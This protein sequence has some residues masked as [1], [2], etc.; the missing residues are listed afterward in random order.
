MLQRFSSLLK[1]GALLFVVGSLSSVL[2]VVLINMLLYIRALLSQGIATDSTSQQVWG[3]SIAHGVYMATS[4]NLRYQ[5][6]GGLIE[7][8]GLNKAFAQQQTISAVLSFVIRTVNTYIGS[9]QW[10]DF[11]RYLGLQQA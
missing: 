9:A 7:E 1:N 11:L 6:I 5:V 3:I 10:V 8:R 4:G 2:G